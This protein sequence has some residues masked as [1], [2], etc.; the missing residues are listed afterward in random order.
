[1]ALRQPVLRA[2]LGQFSFPVFAKNKPNIQHF[3]LTNFNTLT[4]FFSR[5]AGTLPAS[6]KPLAVLLKPEACISQLFTKQSAQ[7]HATC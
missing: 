2:G 1:M 4:Y 3:S 6:G 5:E 7:L